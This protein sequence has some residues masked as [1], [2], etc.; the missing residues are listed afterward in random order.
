MY[1]LYSVDYIPVYYFFVHRGFAETSFR[2]CCHQPKIFQTLVVAWWWKI[3][4]KCINVC[5]CYAVLSV[6][7][8]CQFYLVDSVVNLCVCPA[9]K[10]S[11][12]IPLMVEE[13]DFDDVSFSGKIMTLWSSNSPVIYHIIAAVLWRNEQQLPCSVA[14]SFAVCNSY[15]QLYENFV[16]SIACPCYIHYTQ[17]LPLT[18]PLTVCGK[19]V[20]FVF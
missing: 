17:S 12:P 7:S 16:K 11:A 8:F 3:R 15:K 19:S 4:S 20:C 18:V 2:N 13:M 10:R 5:A 9:A 6:Y 14:V 1:A